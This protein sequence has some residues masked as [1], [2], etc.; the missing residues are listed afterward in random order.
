MRGVQVLGHANR[1]TDQAV[2]HLQGQSMA[3]HQSLEK[4]GQEMMVAALFAAIL[5]AGAALRFWHLTELPA[6]LYPDEAFYGTDALRSMASGAWEVFYPNNNG[7]EGLIVWLHAP[8]ILAFGTAPW[9]LRLQPALIGSLTLVAIYLLG[10]EF[11]QSFTAG[12][13]TGARRLGLIGML[14]LATNG[15]HLHLSR[16]GFRA[17]HV[18]LFATLAVWGLLRARRLGA[19]RDYALSGVMTALAIYTYPNGRFV[20][21]VPLGMFLLD[22]IAAHAERGE[23]RLKGNG[24]AI[25]AAAFAA[26]FI[27]LGAYYVLHLPEFLA[28]YQQVGFSSSASPVRELLRSFYRTLQSPF[29][30]GDGTWRHN[31]SGAPFLNPLVA[32]ACFLGLL[33]AFTS[34]AHRARLIRAPAAAAALRPYG[35]TVLLLFVGVMSVPAILTTE[36]IPHALRSGGMLPPLILAAA[37]VADIALGWA[38][39]AAPDLG[40]RIAVAAVVGFAAMLLMQSA[41]YEYFALWAENPKSRLA[42]YPDMTELALQLDR[43]PDDLP[44]YVVTNRAGVTGDLHWL[45]QPIV[46]ITDTAALSQQQRRNLHYVTVPELQA[47][48]APNER[49]LYVLIDEAVPARA[50][51]REQA[52][53]AEIQV[54]AHSWQQMQDLTH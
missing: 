38:M 31:V 20:L 1:G 36:S 51:L 14:F 52:P 53:A 16:L 46:F 21:F 26:A 45:V 29:F 27:P 37:V 7:H 44:K 33:L 54:V 32:F 30:F 22:W 39:R 10:L 11:G 2:A 23:E 13:G 47:K 15:W 3:G 42:F 19:G 24:F 49:S 28:R 6:A 5:A 18:P 40:G 43:L 41:W 35:A 48:G 17:V 8:F 50:W 9:V 12:G 4:I 25:F 34:V